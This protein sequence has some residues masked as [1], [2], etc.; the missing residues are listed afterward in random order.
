M[1]IFELEND[2]A[3]DLL[4]PN[5]RVDLDRST[6]WDRRPAPPHRPPS[7]RAAADADRAHRQYRRQQQS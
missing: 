5:K 1:K 7:P 2:A 6:Q 3:L 4:E